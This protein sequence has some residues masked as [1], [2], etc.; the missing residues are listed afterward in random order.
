MA[1]I[2][3]LINPFQKRIATL[4]TDHPILEHALIASRDA[5]FVAVL[6]FIF[7]LV[8]GSR[9]SPT[10]RHLLWLTVAIRLAM[11]AVP[12]SELSWQRVLPQISGPVL[13]AGGEQMRKSAELEVSDGERGESAGYIA[14]QQSEL[15]MNVAGGDSAAVVVVGRANIDWLHIAQ[16]LWLCGMVCYLMVMVAAYV[17]FLRRIN[18]NSYPMSSE[19]SERI[20]R[21][22]R[23]A[24][25]HARLQGIARLKV[26]LTDAI[27]TPAIYGFFRPTILLPAALPDEISDDELRLVI[28]H[29]LGHLRRGDIWI[30]WGLCLL[31]AVHWFN[32]IVWLSFW[33]IRS[34]AE[35]AC[36][37][38]VLQRLGQHYARPY[39][40]LLL[41]LL[42]TTRPALAPPGMHGVVESVADIR[43]RIKDIASYRD[44]HRAAIVVGIVAFGLLAVVGL[45]QPPS[46]VGKPYRGTE[47]MVVGSIFDYDNR[48]L[49]NVKVQLQLIEPLLKEASS[50]HAFDDDSQRV[51]LTETDKF[52]RFEFVDMLP[53]EYFI[54]YKLPDTSRENL[55]LRS[56][57]FRLLKGQKTIS[58]TMS[59]GA[60][61]H[62]KVSPY[63]P[64]EAALILQ[65]VDFPYSLPEEP[66]HEYYGR[67]D[68]SFHYRMIVPSGPGRLSSTL[69]RDLGSPGD[70]GDSF[71][72]SL[73]LQ[74]G[75]KVQVD[76]LIPMSPS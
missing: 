45:T 59:E 15:E 41:K 48:P 10:W 68:A 8:L 37:H 30:G 42:D 66:L 38:W 39:G 46:D 50:V 36:D 40:E 28:I 14:P 25:V 5:S 47:P 32:P 51:F 12:S 54:N 65:Y 71:E 44:C 23:S 24:I 18:R 33:R 11:P 49:G 56:Q 43:R 73:S 57:T 55:F 34:E 53:G 7:T 16:W 20:D 74:S 9:I 31:Q 4:M 52:G 35:K 69:F 67:V 70:L 1:A 13:S 22:V 29:E 64:D 72:K 19:L 21:L 26:R 2:E 62:G 60:V 75:D 61:L 3:I 17:L 76:I 27:H 63:D 6:V 58:Q